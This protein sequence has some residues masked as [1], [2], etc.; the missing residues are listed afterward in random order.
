MVSLKAKRISIVTA[1]I[2]ILTACSGFVK[3]SI[4]TPTTIIDRPI[5]V[6][7]L[8]QAIP[9]SIDLP[10]GWTASGEGATSMTQTLEPHSGLGYGVCSGPDWDGL[11][12]KYGVVAWVWSPQINFPSGATGYIGAFEFSNSTAVAQ[13]IE[14]SAKQTAC[15]TE[16]FVAIEYNGGESTANSPDMVRVDLIDGSD[17]S[18]KW[19]ITVVHST[20]G[21]LPSSKAPGITL[22]HSFEYF[23][24]NS[25]ANYGSS[26]EEVSAY[27]QYGN[28]LLRFRLD[29]ACCSYGFANSDT[30]SDDTRPTI[31]ALDDMASQVRLKILTVLG[32]DKVG[33]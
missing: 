33:K 13:F 7:L 17:N 15:G 22:V 23:T 3:D 5:G 8:A 10:S 24:R 18:T 11:L 32:L 25:G 21:T 30:S 4:P 9:G 20:G 14:E 31:A 27:E 26:D 12:I 6:S 28:V 29:G 19:N 1:L 2:L 16:K